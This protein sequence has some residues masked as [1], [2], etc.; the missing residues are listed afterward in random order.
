MAKRIDR[1]NDEW[2]ALLTPQQYQV[3][4]ERGTERAFTGEYFDCKDTGMYHCVAC[5]S[6][7]FSSQDKYDSG[8]GWPSFTAPVD[9]DAIRNETDSSHGMSRTEVLCA[10]CD[11]HLGHVFADGPGPT[12]QR[13]C[14][15]SAALKLRK[16]GGD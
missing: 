7:L 14:L 9:E 5:G 13:F 3:C 4:R 15:N 1:S 8:T 10:S 12:G 6:E 11:S 2:R 16:D